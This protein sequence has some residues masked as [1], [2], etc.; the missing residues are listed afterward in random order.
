MKRLILIFALVFVIIGFT[1]YG[2]EGYSEP[3]SSAELEDY[4]GTYDVVPERY[5][6][7]VNSGWNSGNVKASSTLPGKR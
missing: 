6:Y 7:S 3:L 4:P 5:N 2:S 1:V